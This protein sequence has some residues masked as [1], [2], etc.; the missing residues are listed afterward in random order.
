MR[1]LRYVVVG[2]VIVVL[3]GT[4]RARAQ[5]GAKNGEWRA[6]AG[7]IGSTRYSPIEQI[8]RDNV[9]NLQI[10]WGWKFD[11]YGAPNS[12]TTPI[13]VNGVLY[14]TVGPRRTIVAV[15]PGSGE[16]LWVYRPDEGPRS[17]QAPRKITR[18]VAFW[19]DGRDNR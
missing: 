15:D 8:N 6:Y 16:T 12:E 18:G 3:A 1:E 7:E 17:D 19:T 5:S 9:K 13:M 14:F 4:L 2:F 10:A 11:N